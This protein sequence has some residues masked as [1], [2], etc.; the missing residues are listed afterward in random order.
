LRKKYWMALILPFCL[1][2][3]VF[4]TITQ[5]QD[6]GNSN[7]IESVNGWVDGWAALLEMNEFPEAGWNDLPVNFINSER[8]KASLLSLGWKTDHILEI[9]DDLN[10]QAVQEALEWL[11]NNTDSGDI[12]LFYIFTHGMWMSHV[13][14]WNDWFPAKWKS[15]DTSKKVLIID[16]CHAE[17]FINQVR[18]DESSHISVACCSADEIAWA[19][20]EEEGLPIIGS[21]WNYYFTEA[22]S[23]SSADH[24]GNGIVSVE[25]AFNFSTPLVQKYMNEK[26]FTVPEFLQQYHDLGIY[27]ENFT[28]YPHPVMDDGYTDQLIIPEFPFSIILPIFIVITSAMLVVDK[29]ARAKL[30]V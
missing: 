29:R 30:C 1:G 12:A 22:L 11:C 15:L 28:E 8:M 23:N 17:E 24:D 19:G 7:N 9:R 13:L 6:I 14:H 10:I 21:V 18:D 5:R 25:E 27:P 20:V 2:T 16:T 4:A 26:V 3:I